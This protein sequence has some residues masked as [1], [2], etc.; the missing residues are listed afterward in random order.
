MQ[1]EVPRP[2]ASQC[3]AGAQD[4]LEGWINNSAVLRTGKAV[5][6]KE[7]YAEVERVVLCGGLGDVALKCL[8]PGVL[9]KCGACKLCLVWS[10]WSCRVVNA[11]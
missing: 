3:A 4:K 2:K 11:F 7:A 1:W 9:G 5:S 8:T 6:K 10:S